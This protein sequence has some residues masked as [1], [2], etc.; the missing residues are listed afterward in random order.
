MRIIRQ[1]VV[2]FVLLTVITGVL[3]P[4]LIT[5]LGQAAFPAQANGSLIERDGEIVGSSLIGQAT[6]DP[7]YFWSR[8]SGVSYM[9]GSSSD[10]LAVS[11]GTNI[12]WTNAALVAAV[13]EREAAF[14][15]ANNVP[16]EVAVPPEMLFASGSGLDPHISPASARLQIER[17]AMARGLDQ[18]Q[19]AAL[20]E[21]QIESPQLAIL[22]EARV[23]VLLLNLAL[24]GL[25]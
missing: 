13:A 4:M 10:A 22:G 25:Q 9:L 8:P 3:Y 23:N 18:A 17:V 20:V 19:I 21:Q 24:D 6:D 15:A 11:S 5:V 14:R 12:G 7:R 16:A 1:A 2:M